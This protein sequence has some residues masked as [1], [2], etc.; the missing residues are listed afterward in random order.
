MGALRNTR[1]TNSTSVVM[2][3]LWCF[4]FGYPG[5]YL[6]RVLIAGYAAVSGVRKCSYNDVYAGVPEVPVLCPG[7]T[8]P[9][10]Y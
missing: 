7:Q 1:V 3:L 2:L 6:S 9:K 5:V 8:K 4:Y 10:D